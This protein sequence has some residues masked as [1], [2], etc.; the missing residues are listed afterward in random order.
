MYI[1]FKKNISIARF[2]ADD[3]IDNYGITFE[4]V[5]VNSSDGFL[6]K[7]WVSFVSAYAPTIVLCHGL[8][9]SKHT[10]LIHAH[11]L[12]QAGYN[13]LLF[14]FR[15]HGE[16][17][18]EK[19]SFGYLEKNDFKAVIDYLL[20]REDLQCKKIGVL[21]ES[22]GAA[23][24]ILASGDYPEIRALCV[25]S[26]YPELYQGFTNVVQRLGLPRFPFANIARLFYEL[27]FRVSIKTI[28]PVDV[29]GRLSPRALFFIVGTLDARI[30]LEYSERLCAAA[31]APKHIWIIRDARHVEAHA[32]EPIEYQRKVIAFFK[33][34]L[35][36][37]RQ[38]KNV[39]LLA[40]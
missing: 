14:D 33:K 6:I 1:L 39:L 18:G 37:S 5:E 11:Y 17:S 8:G 24:S 21:G 4:H 40:K 10:M 32:L 13:V 3:T 28:S 31:R 9:S 12:I 19:T 27:H 38:S 7:C 15:A 30:P 23:V 22:M 34:Y 2:K 36:M 26:C 20:S 29:V 35:T 16:S 25:D